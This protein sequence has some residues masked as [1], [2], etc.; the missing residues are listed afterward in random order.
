MYHLEADLATTPNRPIIPII[1][2]RNFMQALHNALRTIPDF[3]KPG[4]QFKDIAPLL[5]NPRH[6]N[7]TIEALKA[8][9]LNDQL[10]QIVGIESRGFLFASALAYALGCGTTLIRKP[11]KLP[12]TVHQ[13]TYD[14]EYGSDALEIQTDALQT[15]HRVLLIGDVLA[16]GGTVAAARRLIENHFDIHLVGATFL[17]ELTELKGRAK[18]AALPVHTLIQTD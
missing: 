11:G 14:L 1:N 2:E 16:T 15:G 8:H 13:Q 5:A 3:P 18:L 17:L 12:G 10:D 4:I 9:H 7:E 6:F